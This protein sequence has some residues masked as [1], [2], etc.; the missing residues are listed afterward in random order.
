MASLFYQ[1]LVVLDLHQKRIFFNTYQGRNSAQTKQL[2]GKLRPVP[3][4]SARSVDVYMKLRCTQKYIVLLSFAI[5]MLIFTGCQLIGLGERLKPLSELGTIS[6][7][8]TSD[9]QRPKTIA[10]FAYTREDGH[11]RIVRYKI[12]P[13]SGEYSFVL[14]MG[15]YY[16]AAFEDRNGDFVYEPGEVAGILRKPEK[17]I[18]KANETYPGSD[19]RI[20]HKKPD[21]LYFSVNLSLNE[22][23]ASATPLSSRVARVASLA[24]S[25][26]DDKKGDMGLWDFTRFMHEGCSGLYFLE[27]YNPKKIPVLFIHGYTGTPRDF[28]FLFAGLD[29]NKFQPWFVF[30]PSAMRISMTTDYISSF[31]TQ[32]H[33]IHHFPRLFVVGYS[34]GGLVG[35]SFILQNAAEQRKNFIRLFVSISTPWNGHY[36]ADFRNL[37]PAQAPSWED[38]AI[39]SD[40]LTSLFARPFPKDTR[41]YLLFGYKGD[42]NLLRPNN[43]GFITLESALDVRAQAEAVKVYGLNKGHEEIIASPELSELLNKILSEAA[44]AP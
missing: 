7:R 9:A 16:L 10:V 6:G 23:K 17:I 15:T 2:Y 25:C 30:Y 8:V 5:S 33:I 11:P 18:L 43:D 38:L 20:S 19:I 3:S 22:K 14:P 39:G 40:F 29:R 36:L 35:R 42:R 41:Y 12:L 37:A 31:I 13:R 1:Y 24:D 26:F 44:N 34:M 27:P 28:K 21:H 4:G 32:L